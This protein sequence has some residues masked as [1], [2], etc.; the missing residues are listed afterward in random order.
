MPNKIQSNAAIQSSKLK[1]K[2]KRRKCCCHE[3]T[4]WL[5]CGKVSSLT[6]KSKAPQAML[7]IKNLA[8]EIVFNH[9]SMHIHIHPFIHLGWLFASRLT[10]SGSARLPAQSSARLLTAAAKPWGLGWSL[11]RTTGL[12]ESAAP[13]G[14]TLTG[15]EQQQRPSGRGRAPPHPSWSLSRLTQRIITTTFFVPPRSSHSQII[16]H[17]LIEEVCWISLQPPQ[18]H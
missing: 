18:L 12:N 9:R 16:R 13:W 11:W 3:Y 2:K 5:E 7:V 17:L 6:V 4:C 10:V 15:A 1:K 14:L 8:V